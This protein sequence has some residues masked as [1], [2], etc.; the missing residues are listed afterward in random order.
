MSQLPDVNQFAAAA[1]RPAVADGD[2]AETI[3]LTQPGEFIYG[4]VVAVRDVNTQYGN[5]TV[6]EVNDQQRGVVSMWVS[7]VQLVAGLVE[8]NNQLQRPVQRGDLLYV[9]FDGKQELDNGRQVSNFAINVAAGQPPPQPAQAP[10]QVASPQQQ[11]GYQQQP[12]QPAP[13]QQWQQPAPQQW[14]QPQQQ[15]QQQPVDPQQ[16]VPF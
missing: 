16:H 5:K 8:G 7:N 6:L 13:A 9:R 15:P 11:N 1:Q 12:Q 4:Q 2:F 10:V 14:P 3:K